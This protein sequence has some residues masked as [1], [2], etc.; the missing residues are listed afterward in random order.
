MIKN[1]GR[2]V[3]N[4]DQEKWSAE[5]ESVVYK[6]ILAKFSSDQ[7]LKK[8]LVETGDD[9]LAE[10]SPLDKIW[11]IGLAPNDPKVQD[12]NAWDGSN[13]LGK[14]LMKARDALRE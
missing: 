5:C 6:A 9:I 13:L 8:I 14:C 1:Y 4:F 10:A 2:E 7:H 12:I 11:G 3:Q